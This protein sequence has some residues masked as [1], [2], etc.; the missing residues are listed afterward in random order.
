MDPHRPRRVALATAAE[1]VDPDPDLPALAAALADVGCDAEVVVWTDAAVDWS[2]TDAVV[3]RSTWDY[4]REVDRFLAWCTEVASVTTLWNPLE[5]VRWNVDKRYLVELASAGV[6]VVPTT[7]VEPGPAAPTDIDRALRLLDH[8]D[9]VVKPAVGAGSIDADRHADRTT[10]AAHLRRLVDAGRAAL[11]QPYVA[12]I[13]D[14][15]ELDLVFV[16]GEWSHAFGKGALLT[17]RRSVVGGLYVAEELASVTPPARALDVATAIVDHVVRRG[18]VPLY[19]RVDLVPDG[20]RYRLLELELVEPS[21]NHHLHPPS[22][23]ALARAIA[24]RLG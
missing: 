3:L 8:G 11:V 22:A 2:R 24:R 4:P 10:A 16:D 5:L 20:A 1:A 12:A 17:A 19:A 13:D 21:L 9:V 23:D 14:D 15:G 6:D 18:D 7:L